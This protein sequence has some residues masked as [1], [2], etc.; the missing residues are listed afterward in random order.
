M[1]GKLRELE[2]FDGEKSFFIIPAANTELRKLL[3]EH[4]AGYKEEIEKEIS[5]KIT[6]K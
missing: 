5:K 4:A 2:S 6:K 1:N 3:H